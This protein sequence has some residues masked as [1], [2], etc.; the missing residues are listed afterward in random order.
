MTKIDITKLS[1]E[2]LK[3]LQEQMSSL[4][5]KKKEERDLYKK[6]VDEDVRKIVPEFV[7]FQLNQQK[8]VDRAFAH[9]GDVLDLKK[10]IFGYP[11]D[12]SS[13]TFTDRD[14]T[15][16]V[17][18]GY[19]EIVGF[20]GTESAGILK[21]REYIKSLSGDDEKRKIL[22]SLLETFM[23][24]N[25]RGELNPSRV[26]ELI[27]QKDKVNDPVFSEGVDIIVNAQFKRRS[28]SY[29]RGWLMKGDDKIEFSITS[30]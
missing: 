18:I 17:T 13:H 16:S 23:K 29:V 27:S 7:E 14:G 12:Q 15:S 30:K 5:N 8:M 3:S 4:E 1:A 19:N 2:E 21:I 6:L 10:E 22:G 26:A 24:P 25:K 11:E 9:F 28:S 20:D